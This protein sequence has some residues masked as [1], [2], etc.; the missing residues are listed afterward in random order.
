MKKYDI[1]VVGAGPAG[2]CFAGHITNKNVLVIDRKH[3]LGRPVKSSAGTF[4]DTLIDFGLED[5]VRHSS[6]GFRIILG[7]GFTRGFHYEKPVLHTLDFPRMIEILSERARNN[8]EII[9][10][11]SVE[12]VTIKNGTIDSI[13][14]EDTTFKADLFIDASGETRALLKHLAPLYYQKQ[15]LAYGLEYEAAGLDMNADHFDF[16]F[17]NTIIPEGY[18]WIFPTGTTTAR[19]GLGKLVY[20]KGGTKKVNLKAALHD[21][22]SSGIISVMNFNEN[23]ITE[24][25][26]GTMTYYKPLK[27]PSFNNC[28]VIGDASSQSSCFLGEGIRF[29]LMSARKL[30]IALNSHDIETT[31]MHYQNYISNMTRYFNICMIFLHFYKLAPDRAIHALMKALTDYDNANMLRILRSEFKRTDFARLLYTVPKNAIL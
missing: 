21:F 8:C 17:G 26:G 29:S 5:A 24:T 15:W 16:F 23:N 2:L 18:A 27:N 12:K 28:F 30:A 13:E 19:I 9:H 6:N 20:G 7:N 25:H 11:A 31:R 3:E 1:I 14:I 4:T 22:I 10:P